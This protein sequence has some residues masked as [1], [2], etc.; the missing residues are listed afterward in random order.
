MVQ[1]QSPAGAR[2]LILSEALRHVPGFAQ[3]EARVTRIEGGTVNRSFIVET[4][5]GRYFLRLHEAV[6]VALGADHAREARLQAAAAQAGLAPP[7]IHADPAHRFAISEFL[8][9]RVWTP[10]D[11]EI[12][13]QVRRLGTTLRRVHEVLPPIAAPFDLAALLEDFVE[14]IIAA[15]PTERSSLTALM[16]RARAMLEQVASDKRPATLFHSDPHHSNLIERPDGRLQLV[17]WEYAAVADPLYDLACVLAYYPA[18]EP[19]APVLLEAAGLADVASPSMLAHA[20]WLYTFL[21]SLWFRARRL[22]TA[23][24]AEDLR[25]ERSML[26][27]LV[28]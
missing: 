27:R 16:K 18:A 7:L 5:A 14:R 25:T 15:E 28:R 6:S 24:D 19:H 17:D 13:D 23:A 4:P 21:G 22:D 1:G 3:S 12:A 20:T 26:E 2:D 9:G 11:F 8:D 10:A